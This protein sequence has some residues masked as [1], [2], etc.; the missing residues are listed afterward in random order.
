MRNKKGMLLAE[1]NLKVILAILAILLLLYLFFNWYSSLIEQ[2]NFQ[3][4]EASLVSLQEKMIDAKSGVVTLPLLEPNGW[5]LV[6]YTDYNRPESCQGNCICLCEGIGSF[7]RAKLFWAPTQLEKCEIRGV[8]KS[9][10][11]DINKLDI[12]LRVQVKI[13]YDGGYAI[14]EDVKIE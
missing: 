4:A 13:Q 9:L 11:D 2:R 7:D 8:C 1:Y 3:R 6:S 10:E 5:R 12:G 14:S